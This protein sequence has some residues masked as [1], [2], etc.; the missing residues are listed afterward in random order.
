MPWLSNICILFLINIKALVIPTYMY[1][2]V[3][4]QLDEHSINCRCHGTI[5]F[6]H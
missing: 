2:L 5:A 3:D 6:G 1:L 4:G